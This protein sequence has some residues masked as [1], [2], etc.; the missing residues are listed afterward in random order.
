MTQSRHYSKMGRDGMGT[1]CEKKTMIWWRN[2]W[3]TKWRLPD[4]ETD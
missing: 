3:S 2:V 1:C 4:Q